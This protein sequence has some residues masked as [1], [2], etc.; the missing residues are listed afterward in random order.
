V[1]GVLVGAVLVFLIV[2]G[3]V[4]RPRG[5]YRQPMGSAGAPA[6]G[7]VPTAQA[8][9]RVRALSDQGQKITAIK[10]LR[11]ATGLG[12]KEA[13]ETVEAMQEGRP[14]PHLP[15]AALSPGGSPG[16][17]SLAERASALRAAGDYSGAVA[18]VRAETG[19]TD[20][21]AMRFIAALSEPGD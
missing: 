2:L 3:I 13:K 15:M 9:E 6:A 7:K 19:M 14:T 12:L 18:L 10:E 8:M 4:T 1:I 17:G 11:I 21:D 16:E 20:G 5:S